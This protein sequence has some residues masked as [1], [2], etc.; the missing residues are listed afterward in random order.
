MERIFTKNKKP[1]KLTKRYSNQKL[2][3]LL[4]IL[5]DSELCRT[6]IIIIG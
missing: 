1:C 4:N 2:Y 3:N 6:L 5:K